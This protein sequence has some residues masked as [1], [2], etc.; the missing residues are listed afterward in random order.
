[1]HNAAVIALLQ[2]GIQMRTTT[3]AYEFSPTTAVAAAASGSDVSELSFFPLKV[4]QGFEVICMGESIALIIV[5]CFSRT[6]SI[7]YSP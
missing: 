6:T 2:N 7:A 5:L 1:M 4:Q 3:F